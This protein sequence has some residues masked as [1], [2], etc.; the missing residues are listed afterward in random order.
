MQIDK[1]NKINKMHKHKIGK[2]LYPI[3]DNKEHLYMSDGC[4]LKK[5]V[6]SWKYNRPVDNMK[7]AE[8]VKLTEEN[9]RNTIEGVIYVAHINGKYVCYDGNHRLEALKLLNS[10]KLV[11]VNLM[12]AKNDDEIK[13]RFIEIN[14]ANP[15]PELYTIDTTDVS[16]QLRKSIDEI[17]NNITSNKQFAKFRS[18]SKHPQRPNFN[19]D[20]LTDMLYNKLKNTD[21]KKIVPNKIFNDIINLNLEYSREIHMKHSDYSTAMTK[22]CRKCGCYLFLKKDFTDDLVV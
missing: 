15:V 4:F 16:E 17:V 6:K 3:Q 5:N 20:K 7:I 14:R 2:H 1:I 12:I 21:I 9:S 18:A 11:L 8:I 22:K 19:K 10:K 13:R